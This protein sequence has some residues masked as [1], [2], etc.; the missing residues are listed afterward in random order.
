MTKISIEEFKK[1]LKEEPIVIDVR[2]PEEINVGKIRPDALEID[3]YSSKVPL[4]IQGLDKNKKYVLYCRTGVRS[5]SVADYMKQI[6]FKEVY[7]ID[8][9]ISAWE[10]SNN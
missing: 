1:M 2:T 5:K 8:G 4:K 9:G 3:C 6:G 7:D 10:E